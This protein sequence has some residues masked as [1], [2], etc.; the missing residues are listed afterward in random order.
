MCRRPAQPARFELEFTAD[1]YATEEVADSVTARTPK[2]AATNKTSAKA[3]TSKTAAAMK[4]A[5]K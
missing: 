5:K 1:D 2:T 4:A 3:T